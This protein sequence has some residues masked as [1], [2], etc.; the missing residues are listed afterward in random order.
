[1]G[2]LTNVGSWLAPALINKLTPKQPVPLEKATSVNGATS[3]YN[4][5]TAPI[6]ATA[7]EPVLADPVYNYNMPSVES[8]SWDDALAQAEAMYKPEYE[9]SVLRRDKMASDQRESLGQM[10]AARGYANPRG[11]KVESGQGNITQSQA[12]DLQDMGNQ[13]MAAKA[14]AARTIAKEGRDSAQMNLQNL[15]ALQNQK[16]QNTWNT[17]N[18][19]QQAAMQKK[20]QE[21]DTY[22]KYFDYFSKMMDNYPSAVG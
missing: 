21:D 13:Y 11:G 2:V 20:T 4:Y 5:G 7:A 15:I 16:N 1:M 19:K 14:Q 6:P 18:V 17:W 22:M 3:N 9:S 10:M 12:I 8:I